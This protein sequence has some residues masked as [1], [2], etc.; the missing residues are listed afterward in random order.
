MATDFRNGLLNW[1]VSGSEVDRPTVDSFN[2]GSFRGK[3]RVMIDS[4]QAPRDKNGNPYLLVNL[5]S[6]A[7]P[8]WHYSARYFNE[9]LASPML[10]ALKVQTLTGETDD[11]LSEQLVGRTMLIEFVVRRGV[12]GREHLNIGNHYIDETP[13]SE[14]EPF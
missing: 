4:C 8:K 2:E 9:S 14:Q 13:I 6:T 3:Q 5:S 10:R 7:S 11:Q 12:D 1:S